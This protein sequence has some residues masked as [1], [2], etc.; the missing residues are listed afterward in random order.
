M[1][2]K[3]AQ[4]SSLKPGGKKKQMSSSTLRFHNHFKFMRKK[5]KKLAIVYRRLGNKTL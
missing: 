5:T 1:A 3:K 4:L 2:A